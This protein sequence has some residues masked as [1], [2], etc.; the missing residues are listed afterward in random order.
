M[1]GGSLRREHSRWHLQGRRSGISLDVLYNVKKS[2]RGIDVFFRKGS[3][4]RMVLETTEKALRSG[5]LVPIPT[6]YDFIQDGGIR[7]YVRVLDTLRRK[8]EER[9]RQEAAASRG[10]NANPFLSPERELVVADV[11]NTHLA[12]LNKF[13]VLEHHLLIITRGF[14]KQDMLMTMRDFE[15]LWLCMAEY[16]ALGFYNGGREAG[17]SQDHRH[18]QMVPLPLAPSGPAVPIDPILSDVVWRGKIGEVS[19]LPF[20]HAFARLEPG[21]VDSPLDAAKMSFELYGEMLMAVGME[22]PDREGLKPQSMPY[23]LLVTR[24]WML[25]VPRAKEFFEGVSLNSLAFAGSLFV[26]DES[27]LRLLRECGPMQALAS[28]CLPRKD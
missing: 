16:G 11:S 28:V 18:I 27:Q 13:N 12:I 22:P 9:K 20:L 21:L 17:A 3:L 19:G 25:L 10:Q 26:Q 1:R 2:K 23:C 8:H 14:E 4:W 24:D 7:F 5:A 6:V 15:A